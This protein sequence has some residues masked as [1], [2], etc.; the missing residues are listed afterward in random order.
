LLK[1]VALAALQCVGDV[2][3]VP[4]SRHGYTALSGEEVGESEA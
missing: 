2:A 1:E 3:R 4:L